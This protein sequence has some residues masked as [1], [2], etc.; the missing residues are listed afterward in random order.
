MKKSFSRIIAAALSAAMLTCLFCAAPFTASAKD[1]KPFVI[2]T[3]SNFFSSAQTIYPDIT[4]Y[5]DENG[6]IFVAAEY[7]LLG[8]NKYLINLAVDELTWD[9]EVLEFREAYN[10]F[11]AGSRP[12]FTIFP[13]AYEQ[14]MGSG[15]INDYGDSN[16]GTLAANYSSINPAADAFE[17]DGSPIT[18]IKAVFKLLDRNAG[19]TTVKCIINTISLCSKDAFEPHVQFS[20]IS[21]GEIKEEYVGSV[22]CYSK[23]TP[24]SAFVVGDLDGDGKVTI[25]DATR[26]QSVFAEADN[27]FDLSNP[28]AAAMIDFN[29]DGKANIKDITQIQRTLAEK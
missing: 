20:V 7:R 25:N 14:G 9:P 18:L 12:V 23:V 29:R 2:R 17:E 28:A 15:M 13:F 19:E 26:I 16:C 4:E 11:G 21:A 24:D 3:E 8:E 27:S 5:E 22:S 10:S 6:D 1:K